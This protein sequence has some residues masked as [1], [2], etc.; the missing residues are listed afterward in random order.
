[1][2]I[3]ASQSPR[4]AELL[5]QIGVPFTALSA[6]IDESILPNETPENYVQR[7]AQQKAQAGWRASADTAKRRLVLG[8]DT[9]V[10]I[11]E[12]VMGKP[13][14]FDDAKAMLNLLSGQQH[15]VLT[16]VTVTSGQRFE[17]ILVKTDVTFCAL[18]PSQI[19]AYWQTGEPKDKAGSYAIQGIGGKFVTHIKGS[20]SAVVGL[21]LYETNQLLSRMSQAHEC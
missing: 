21:P 2:L 9:V 18:S 12:Q 5:S 3:L 4:R 19:E 13:K 8:A 15:Q 7:L 11:N 16:A 17:T 14:D 10:V 20:Y 6:D 1:M